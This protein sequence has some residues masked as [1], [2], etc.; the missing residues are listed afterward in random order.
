MTILNDKPRLV[1]K[2]SDIA[3]L[4]REWLRSCDVIDQDKA[5]LFVLILDVRSHIR[6]VE[7]VS[8]GILN[9]NLVH[10]RE[11]YRRAI[12]EGAAQIIIAHNHPSNIPNPSDE[13]IEITR[14][15]SQ[16]GEIV[17]IPL[18]DHVIFTMQGYYSFTENDLFIR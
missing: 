17:G 7:V 12:A 13:D 8:I 11:V 1:T 4:L 5:H 14:R 15:I 9:A 10:P 3:H 18:I 16:A 6:V 2:P